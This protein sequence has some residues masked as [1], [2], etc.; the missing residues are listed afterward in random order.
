MAFARGSLP[1]GSS[2]PGAGDD[3]WDVVTL[4]YTRDGSVTALTAQS[5]SA[6]AASAPSRGARVV[7]STDTPLPPGLAHDSFNE[8]AM[9][10]L[11]SGTEDGE[12]ALVS[13]VAAADYMR[14]KRSVCVCVCVYVYVCVDCTLLAGHP[15]VRLPYSTTRASRA[16]W[17]T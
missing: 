17:V 7:W 6:S 1:T 8:G 15:C 10:L 3:D 16:R 9:S 11:L 4:W 14:G 5:L 2:E 13:V 12:R